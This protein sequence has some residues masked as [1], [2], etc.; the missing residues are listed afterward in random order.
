[1]IVDEALVELMEEHGSVVNVRCLWEDD[2]FTTSPNHIKTILATDF[3][4]YVK[5]TFLLSKKC[6]VSL[7][8]KFIC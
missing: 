8:L 7:Q 3:Q 1:M 5:G 4:N 2:I 6:H